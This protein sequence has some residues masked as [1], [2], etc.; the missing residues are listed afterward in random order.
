MSSDRETLKV[1]RISFIDMS[2]KFHVQDDETENQKQKKML[3]S[4]GKRNVGANISK[5]TI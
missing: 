5:N 4:T 1:I 3:L 2:F